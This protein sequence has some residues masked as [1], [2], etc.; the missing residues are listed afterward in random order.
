MGARADL[1]G[2]LAINFSAAA[3]GFQAANAYG[4]PSSQI[5]GQVLRQMA[6][7]LNFDPQKLIQAV[8]QVS[9]EEQG[10]GLIGGSVSQSTFLTTVASSQS[11]FLAAVAKKL[12]ISP[13]V[14]EAAFRQALKSVQRND[15]VRSDQ[16]ELSAPSTSSGGTTTS[17]TGGLVNL[18]A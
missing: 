2:S 17:G 5:Q 11:S 15:G 18:L 7:T 4:N 1:Y 6:Q 9:Q 16:K 8:R 10:S 13:Q 14:L 12:G 3:A